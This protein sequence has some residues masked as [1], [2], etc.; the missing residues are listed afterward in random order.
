M[1]TSDVTNE[2]FANLQR[3]LSEAGYLKHGIVG[4][5]ADWKFDFSD[6]REQTLHAVRRFLRDLKCDLDRKDVMLLLFMLDNTNCNGYC[7]G[8]DDDT[9]EW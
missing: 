6:G 9:G 7:A 1:D 3:K 4:N 5:D 2:D 8:N